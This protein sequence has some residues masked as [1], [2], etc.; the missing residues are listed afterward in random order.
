MKC[1]A[2]LTRK[3][4]RG[5]YYGEIAEELGEDEG[6]VRKRLFRAEPLGWI[7]VSVPEQTRITV[8]KAGAKWL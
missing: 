5:P 6:T 2:K 4:G 8:T 1:I 3:L 7:D